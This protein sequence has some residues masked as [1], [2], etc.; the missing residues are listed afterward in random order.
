LKHI[1]NDHVGCDMTFSEFKEIC[2][3][4]WEEKYGFLVID[5]DSDKHK[6]RYRINF[7]QFVFIS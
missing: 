2:S 7:D 3:K 1:Y 5:K 6:G 4:A